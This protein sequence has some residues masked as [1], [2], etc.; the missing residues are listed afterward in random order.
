MMIHVSSV[1]L[2]DGVGTTSAYLSSQ[3]SWSTLKMSHF[4][5]WCYVLYPAAPPS[6]K[7]GGLRL[8]VGHFVG[9]FPIRCTSLDRSTTYYGC[10]G[11]R[12]ARWAYLGARRHVGVGT[13][14]HQL[15]HLSRH[16]LSR[17]PS[18]VRRAVCVHRAACLRCVYCALLLAMPLVHALP[19]CPHRATYAMPAI[20]LCNIPHWCT[21]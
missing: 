21:F 19:D 11:Q 1:T 15:C 12:P 13:S 18:L 20:A 8:A 9:C 3:P 17:G 6:Y 14:A 7:L 16:P 10:L 2:E 5:T 4:S